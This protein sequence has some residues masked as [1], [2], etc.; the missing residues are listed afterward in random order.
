MNGQQIKTC[1]AALALILSTFA[2]N[3]QKSVEKHFER[4][5]G[6]MSVM[7]KDE[8]PLSFSLIVPSPG[9]E[10]NMI[11]LDG[12]FE[13]T[14]VAHQFVFT[15]EYSKSSW[16]VFETADDFLFECAKGDCY[17]KKGKFGLWKEPFHFVSE[18]E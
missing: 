10:D 6:Y 14:E 8:I 17:D 7:F 16:N 15:D 12:I 1:I 2:S 4:A 5:D 13:P 18:E 9:P 3:A 11:V